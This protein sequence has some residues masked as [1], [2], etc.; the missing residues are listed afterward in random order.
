M[1]DCE[2]KNVSERGETWHRYDW[3]KDCGA[4]NDSDYWELPTKS[5]TINTVYKAKEKA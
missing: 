5:K 3:C 2:H 1:S 4:I